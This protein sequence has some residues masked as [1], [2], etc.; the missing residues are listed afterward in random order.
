MLGGKRTERVAEL[1]RVE[2]GTLILMKLKDPRLGFVTITRVEVSPDLRHARVWYSVLKPQASAGQSGQ[3]AEG[4][5]S[6]T[7]PAAGP[8]RSGQTAEGGQSKTA[9]A[10]ESARGFLQHELSAALKLRLTPVLSFELDHS[11]DHSMQIEAI[12]RQIHSNDDKQ[13]DE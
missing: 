5:H 8:G 4:V 12:I 1:I 2:L 11:V 10:L 7:A 6:K 3:T 13:K 9:E